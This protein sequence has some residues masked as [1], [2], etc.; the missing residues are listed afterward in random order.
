MRHVIF[1]IFYVT[2]GIGITAAAESRSGRPTDDSNL[3]M[4]VMIWPGTVA[5]VAY[6]KWTEP[7][8]SCGKVGAE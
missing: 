7:E 8:A 5:A 6:S 3:Y 4:A 1:G 2:I